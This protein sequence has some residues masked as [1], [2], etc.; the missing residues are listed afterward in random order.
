MVR[1]RL[2]PPH[3]PVENGI[4]PLEGL[5]PVIGQHLA[6]LNE[7]IA[8]GEAEMLEFQLNIE[9][10]GGGLKSPHTFGHYFFANAVAGNH[11]NAMGHV[12]SPCQWNDSSLVPDVKATISLRCNLLLNKSGGFMSKLD[13]LAFFQ[14]LA[15]AGNLTTTAQGLG[16]SLSAV[17]KRLKL[18][19]TRLGVT[20]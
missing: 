16:L 2:G 14:H 13:D 15:R 10:L 12:H 7:V 1:H 5:E 9:A 4:K 19:E 17:S 20:L 8:A 11:C 3:S 18:L 6:M